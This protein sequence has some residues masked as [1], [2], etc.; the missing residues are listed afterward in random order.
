MRE[1]YSWWDAWWHWKRQAGEV[2]Y[3]LCD[4][5]CLLLLPGTAAVKRIGQRCD[6]SGTCCFCHEYVAHS[7]CVDGICRCQ[8]G[9]YSNRT[10]NQCLPRM[11]ISLSCRTRCNLIAKASTRLVVLYCVNN[12]TVYI[13]VVLQ[14]AVINVI[15]TLDELWKLQFGIEFISVCIKYDLVEI[16]V[17][18]ILP[19]MLVLGLGL[20]D[21]LNWPWMLGMTLYLTQSA[22]DKNSLLH[23][24]HGVCWQ[25]QYV[26]THG[27]ICL[28]SE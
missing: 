25:W 15:A 7:E 17:E 27:V 14:P 2:L 21:V 12:I 18:V 23:L 26:P 13:T 28:P 22:S 6:A 4:L 1:L 24:C 5:V 20:D 16:M 8:A 19:V 10:G 9:F 11:M 3:M